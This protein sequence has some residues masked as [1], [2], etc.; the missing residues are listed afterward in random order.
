MS[1]NFYHDLTVNVL[2]AETNEIIKKDFSVLLTCDGTLGYYPRLRSIY[3]GQAE[4]HNLNTASHR[5]DENG[6]KSI[7]I[8]FD[9]FG[10]QF[11]DIGYDPNSIKGD[12]LKVTAIQG[13]EINVGWGL[14][15]CTAYLIPRVANIYVSKLR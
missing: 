11:T 3:N 10:D 6:N 4:F 7:K 5:A 12:T 8:Q 2:D 13:D 1:N 9:V 14:T 15:Y